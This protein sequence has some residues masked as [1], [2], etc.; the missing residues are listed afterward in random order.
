[1]RSLTKNPWRWA[2]LASLLFLYAVVGGFS[3]PT[4]PPNS[5]VKILDRNILS[6]RGIARTWIACMTLYLAGAVCAT[7]VDDRLGLVEPMSFRAFWVMP[8]IVAMVVALAW[9]GMFRAAL[10]G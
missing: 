3:D 2:L 10:A 7:V 9:H 4:K 5:T 8:G 1:M 6:E